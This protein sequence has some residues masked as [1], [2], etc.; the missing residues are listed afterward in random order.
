MEEAINLCDF[1]NILRFG[2]HRIRRISCKCFFFRNH[3]LLGMFAEVLAALV[4]FLM[5]GCGICNVLLSRS[6]IATLMLSRAWNCVSESK[7]YGKFH[8]YIRFPYSICLC[9]AKSSS[10]FWTFWLMDFPLDSLRRWGLG[11][12]CGV[13]SF[14]RCSSPWPLAWLLALAYR[15]DCTTSV[16]EQIVR[17]YDFMILFRVLFSIF[18]IQKR[19]FCCWTYQWSDRVFVNSRCSKDE[20]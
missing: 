15:S 20:L 3:S 7:F 2:I 18:R 12:N 11:V 17:F 5:E 1:E 9:M 16:D 19:L 14:L 8:A 10:L 6:C 13:S 4:T